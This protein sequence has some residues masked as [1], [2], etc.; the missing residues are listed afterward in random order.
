VRARYIIGLE[1]SVEPTDRGIAYGDGLFETMA[2]RDGVVQR[3]A[4]HLERLALGCERLELPAP[5]R[6]ELEPQIARATNGIERGS[7]KLI[8]TRGTGPRGYAPPAAPTPTI[9]LMAEASSVAAPFE[10]TLATLNGRLSENPRLAGIKHLNRLEQ[11]LGRLELKH[12]DA[13]EGVMLSTSGI[14]IGGTSRNLF[15]VYGDVIRTPAI[16]H[17][18]IAGVMRRAVLEQCA[19]MNIGTEEC[20]LG[21]DD[22]HDA[23]ELFMTNALVGIQSVTRLDRTGFA[24]RTMALRLARTL[25]SGNH[26]LTGHG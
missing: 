5:D 8:L 23:D 10:L 26:G 4:H 19:R 6:A 13:D 1:S 22:L 3:L 15:A 20:A 17:A 7:L 18:G 16:T 11:V 14:V 2:L 24:S 25:E 9:I 21:P 12:L